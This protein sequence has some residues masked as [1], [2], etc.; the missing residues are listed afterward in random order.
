MDLD[1]E[2][3]IIPAIVTDGSVSAVGG[4]DGSDGPGEGALPWDISGARDGRDGITSDDA[5]GG[6]AQ[7]EALREEDV[8]AGFDDEGLSIP[9]VNANEIKGD[10]GGL[11]VEREGLA[12]IFSR[13]ASEELAPLGGGGGVEGPAFEWV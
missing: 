7:G 4:F 10:G 1:A 11:S 13:E 3:L 8:I 12:E 6:S 5:I 2:F 9:G